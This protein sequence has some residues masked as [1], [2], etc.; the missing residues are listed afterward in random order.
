MSSSLREY[1]RKRNF[2]RT[3]EPRARKGL[4]KG[5]RFVIQKHDASRLHYDFRL[6]MEGTLKSWAVP[7]GVPYQQGEKR[8]AMEVEDHP[9]GYRTFEGTIPKGEYGG[10]TVMVWDEGTYEALGSKSP[11]RDLEAGKL[12]F[13]LHGSKLEGE[14]TLVRMHG[15]EKEWLLIK[16]GEDAK[17]ISKKEDD[18][19]AKTGR[20]LAQIAEEASGP[21][22]EFIEPMKAKPVDA[23]SPG[24]DWE[25]E[26]KF[27]GYRALALKSGAKVDLLSS[28]GKSFNARFP[29]I[30]EG[31][32][33]L[34]GKQLI[35]D[36]EIVALDAE[37][38]S[39]FQKLQAYAL[40]TE[41]PPLAY[42]V[43]DL[44]REDR[45]TCERRRWRSGGGA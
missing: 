20:T 19:S 4:K 7:K 12:H 45:G 30:A 29:E 37:G 22:L 39:S 31:V 21:A 25:Y 34:P 15:K 11:A 14:W 32:A 26:L 33:Q 28:N 8:L 44:L 10:G 36:G 16:S 6:E 9:L 43:F 1:K 23:P 5:H 35:L 2:T 24:S 41:K 17:P 27:D 38:R 18:R 13:I 3:A 40:G 42:Y